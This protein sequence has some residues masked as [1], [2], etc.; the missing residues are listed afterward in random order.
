MTIAK[1]CRVSG[2]VQGVFYRA[3]TQ[4]QANQLGLSGYAKNLPDGSVEV[5]VVGES[6][7]VD[8][9]VRWLWQGSP[10]SQVSD[11][12]V[13]EVDL[14]MAVGKSGQDQFLTS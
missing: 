4:Q 1:L 9:L 3:S 14:E 12:I 2:R 13:I 11:V 5:L 8:E 6:S 7:K 10:R